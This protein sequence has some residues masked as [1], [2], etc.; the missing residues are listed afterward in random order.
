[1]IIQ[2]CKELLHP[3]LRLLWVFIRKQKT[4]GL[5]KRYI[6]RRKSVLTLVII[7]I[8]DWIEKVLRWIREPK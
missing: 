8:Q 1:L 4:M 5:H 2:K 6:E 3:V 7:G